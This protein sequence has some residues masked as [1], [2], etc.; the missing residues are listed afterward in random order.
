MLF[1]STQSFHT[2]L[3]IDW[4]R[5][6]SSMLT[7]SSKWSSDPNLM[8]LTMSS[9]KSTSRLPILIIQWLWNNPSMLQP[10]GNNF[11]NSWSSNLLLSQDYFGQE[12]NMKLGSTSSKMK[13][14]KR[15]LEFIASSSRVIS[16]VLLQSH[17][18]RW[19][20]F[21]LLSILNRASFNPQ[22]HYSFSVWRRISRN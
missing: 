21:S 18:K 12:T 16:H 7:S 20:A 19:K 17:S 14:N 22:I 10:P 1:S 5:M 13:P 15:D 6:T 4:R 11:G 8:F 2:C 3:C 9:W